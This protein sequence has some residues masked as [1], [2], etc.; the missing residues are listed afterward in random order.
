MLQAI[1]GPDRHDPTTLLASREDYLG[2]I[3]QPIDGAVIGIDHAFATEG[4]P[5]EIVRTVH[6][7][8]EVMIDLGAQIRPVTMPWDDA[9]NDAGLTILLAELAHSHADLFPA[10][11]S[12]YGPYAR[13]SIEAGRNIDIAA[14]IAATQCRAAFAGEMGRLFQGVDLMIMPGLGAP[15]PSL[16][17]L[18][19]LASDVDTIRRTLFRFTSPFNLAGV[20]TLSFPGGFSENGL[21]LGLQLVAG[22]W[23][24]GLLCRA[25][26]AYQ[27]V[28]DHHV[29]RP[30]LG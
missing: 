14:Y 30:A 11:A 6:E 7:F 3:T 15:V 20:P 4:L 10:H 23:K 28:T 9:I 2:G 13:A 17:E 29:R 21:P 12:H 26:Y 5:A 25:G 22:K 16:V 27:Q 24:E 8:C 18:Q 1:A 19:A